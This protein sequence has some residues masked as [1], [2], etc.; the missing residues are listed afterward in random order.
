M[1]V[2]A[3]RAKEADLKKQAS[4]RR[5]ATPAVEVAAAEAKVIE[6]TLDVVGDAESPNVAR[7]APKVAGPITFLQA[8][9]GDQVTE[10]QV[11]V[12]IDPREVEAGVASAQAAVAEAQARLAQADA[13]TQS[14]LV[15]IQ[16]SITGGQA[17]VATAQ[18]GLT[19]A[20]RNQAAQIAAAQSS[21]ADFT[22]RISAA[23]ADIRSAQA[24]V[25]AAE[26]NLNNARIKLERTQQLYKGGFIAAQDVDDAKAEV[27]VQEGALAVAQ[28]TVKSRRD[29]AAALVQQRKGAAAQVT[30]VRRQAEA[31]IATANASVKNA[32]ATLATAQANRAQGPA[33]QQNLAALRA[34]VTAAQSAQTQAETRRSDAE[35]RS[36]I[37]GTVTAR[38]GDPGSLAQ[39]GTPVVTVQGLKPLFIEAAI[40][41][42]I[43]GSIQRGAGV[44][45]VFDALPGRTFDGRVEGVNNAA[46]PQN[47][48]FSV[49]VGITNED[50][51][52]RPGMFARV[53]L[54][55][56][57]TEAAVAVPLQAVK[58][59][60]DRATVTVIG[61][62]D[63]AEV[64]EVE[65]GARDGKFVE[66][67][68][69]LRA[70]DRI[71]ILSYNPV[72]DGQKVSI[73]KPK[74]ERGQGGQDRQSGGDRGSRSS[75]AGAPAGGAR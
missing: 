6:S 5:N 2:V 54:V 65:L 43:G 17:G 59:D 35:L 70:G 30:I 56:R 15:G 64:R 28:A 46:D 47:R 62:G 63:K 69:G 61:E 74:E 38:D 31:A 4:G 33:Y 60:R 34:A 11:L 21:V 10:G 22:A 16:G 41:I 53:T 1:R 13:T 55:T 27:K 32:R 58:E 36:P 25:T 9:E 45:I 3:V 57:R 18:A 67:R 14:T 66:I 20:Q 29:A 50:E 19:Q 48:R 23:N 39:P 44:K 8:R 37:S 40:P 68:K 51:A 7:L 42:E 75:G 71:V 72:K 52:V 26:A 73:G 12:R 49:R 24:D